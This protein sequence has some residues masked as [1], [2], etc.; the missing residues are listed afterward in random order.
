MHLQALR[1][2]RNVSQDAPAKLMRLS[3]A[4]VSKTERRD[5]LLLSTLQSFIEALDGELRISAKFPMETIEL[6][7]LRNGARK[8][9]NS[10][11]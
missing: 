3:Q 6:D 4:S 1:E 8:R 10:S 7:L 2:H 9:S 11:R 5:D